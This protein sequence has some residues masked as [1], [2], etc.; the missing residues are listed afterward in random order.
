MLRSPFWLISTAITS[1]RLLNSRWRMHSHSLR[2]WVITTAGYRFITN[3][4]RVA[5]L[6]F[7]ELRDWLARPSPMSQRLKFPGLDYRVVQ[8]MSNDL[9]P[10]SVCVKSVGLQIQLSKRFDWPVSRAAVRR[11]YKV[12]HLR[13]IQVFPF[14]FSAAVCVHVKD[15]LTG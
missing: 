14:S 7:T 12:S 2:C 3:R 10:F 8:G 5:R 11:N 9:V 1:Y 15:L 13:Q 4:V 6:R